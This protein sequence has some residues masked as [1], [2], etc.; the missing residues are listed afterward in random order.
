M[1]SN[2]PST[3]VDEVAART[4][5]QPRALEQGLSGL[6]Y[7]HLPDERP[8][9]TPPEDLHTWLKQLF[10]QA[11]SI[12]FAPHH[13][14]LIEWASRINP[15]DH[16]RPYIAIWPR[17]GG[18]TSI[19]E[20]LVVALGA[21][22]PF[23]ANDQK[24]TEAARNYCLYVSETQRQADKHV[25]EIR[26]RLESQRLGTYY[27]RYASPKTRQ[28]GGTESWSRNRLITGT[29]YVVDA[30]GLNSASRG[31][32][33]EDNRPDLIVFDDIDAKFDSTKITR[34]KEGLIKDTIIPTFGQNAA[35]I[36]VQNKVLPDGVF[37]KLADDR[38][39]YLMRRHV[40]GPLPAIK[41]LETEKRWDDEAE[42][43]I[44]VITSG[45]PTWEGMGLEECQRRIEESGLS[46][47]LRECQHEVEEVEGALWTK[48]QIDAVRVS[49]HPSLRRILVAVDPSGGDAETGIIVVGLGIDGKAYVLD[50][51]SMP[52][53]KAN[54]WGQEVVDAFYEW[55]AD[56]I[57]AEKNQGGEMVRT[58]ILST[59]DNT[60]SVPVYLVHAKRGKEVRADPVAAAYG[61]EE[62]EWKDT[63]V[64]HVGTFKDLE[65]Q[66][67]TW[68]PGNESPDRL[69]ALVYGIKKLIISSTQG[70]QQ[71][72]PPSRSY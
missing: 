11:L 17:F 33:V 71:Q 58:T 65:Q 15:D 19:V 30:L 45:T 48:D 26:R 57:V 38:A 39:D 50:D 5:T 9:K 60:A 35:I 64:C 24:I 6:V 23:V 56:A 34:K 40:S 4:R 61:D 10:P 63:R 1:S 20:C 52:G 53:D 70:Q 43:W 69:D 59:A 32:K 14:E 42:R 46:S 55:Q 27:P 13:Q 44:D 49:N 54:A 67:T 16:P 72:T 18:K 68:V 51:R 62:I 21:P 36:G 25:E 7:R 8:G 22:R 41:D 3:W 12:D 47:F 2:E 37:A 29:G 31:V 66:M 28:Y